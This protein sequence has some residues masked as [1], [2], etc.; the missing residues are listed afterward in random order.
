M[1]CVCWV[2]FYIV[3]FLSVSCSALSIDHGSVTSDT[4]VGSV[5]TYTCDSGYVLVG[6]S[7]QRTCQDNG[8]WDG[9]ELSC[10]CK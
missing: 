10:I 4:T 7:Q 2:L 6:G 8:T 3:V 9:N 5:A 1:F